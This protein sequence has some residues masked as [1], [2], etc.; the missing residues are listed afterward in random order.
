MTRSFAS[1]LLLLSGRV[2][3]KIPHLFLDNGV[4]FLKYS[5]C[6]L[7]M[8]SIIIPAYNSRATIVEALDSVSAQTF[9]RISRA[10]LHEFYQLLEA[11][12][13]NSQ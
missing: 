10:K 11:D 13:G 5:V 7:S 8:I 1:I 2:I 4:G 6:G 3:F 12:K 9:G